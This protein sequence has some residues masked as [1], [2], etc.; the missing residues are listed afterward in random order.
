MWSLIVAA[1]SRKIRAKRFIEALRIAGLGPRTMEFGF[2]GRRQL[3]ARNNTLLGV[4]GGNR[5]A[6]RC[7]CVSEIVDQESEFQ[8]PDV[9]V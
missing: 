5:D 7:E 3:S 1:V 2:W 8:N 9:W 6:A 4:R